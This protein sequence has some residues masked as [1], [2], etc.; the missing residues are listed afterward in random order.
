LTHIGDDVSEMLDVVPASYRVIRIVRPKFS[1]QQCDTLVQ[2]AAP[3]RVI[4]KGLAS[5]ALLTQVVVDKYL[6]RRQLG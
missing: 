2:G 4:K 3:E 1:C 5:A 6:V